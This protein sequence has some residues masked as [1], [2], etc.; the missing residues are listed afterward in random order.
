MKQLDGVRFPLLLHLVERA[1]ND[2]LGHGLL[3]L[4]HDGVHELGQRGVPEFR[5]GDNLALV[6]STSP[7]H[8]V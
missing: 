3:A 8:V 6:C 5:V 7:R 1:V 2:A 4:L